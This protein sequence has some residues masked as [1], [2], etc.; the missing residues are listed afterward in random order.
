MIDRQQLDRPSDRD[1]KRPLVSV[2]IPCF[3]AERYV[4]TALESVLAQTYGPIEVIVV[5]DGSTDGSAQIVAGFA[6]RGVVLIKH[7][8]G[9]ASTARNYAFA[10]STGDFALFLDADDL[11]APDHVAAL[12]D[13]LHPGCRT[14]AMG[15]WDRF[16][17]DSAEACFPD[18]PGYHD[19]I[20]IDWLCEDWRSGRPMTQCGTF[21][22]PRSLLVEVGGWDDR[23]SLIDDFEFFAR[24]LC[25]ADG[26]VFAPDARLYYRSV[27]NSLSAQ[28]SPAAAASAA[29]SLRL[30]TDH[31]LAA[32]DS[33]RTRRAAANMLQTFAY[34][35]Y[36][37]YADLRRQ[38]ALR[39]AELGGSDLVPDGPPGF[40]KLRR[41]IGWRGARRVQRLATRL[42][43]NRAGRTSSSNG[44]AA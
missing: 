25:A 38:I 42:G 9:L 15:Q 31:L 20:G 44:G 29:L 4:G 14:V 11:I 33:P 37:A 32:E 23:L 13:C 17:M 22:I 41:W 36:P 1:S 18:R 28:V 12:V 27:A 39:I 43:L 3:N 7:R 2:L 34:T 16:A 30:G 40:H 19:A 6:D 26:L 5:D 24:V 35:F 8:C 21:L 10:S